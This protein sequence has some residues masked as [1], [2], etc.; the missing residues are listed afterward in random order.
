MPFSQLHFVLSLC[1]GAIVF[2]VTVTGWVPSTS[3]RGSV[4]TSVRA[5]PASYIPVYIPTSRGGGG[6]SGG[7]WSGG[8]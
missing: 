1:V 8:K 7:G 2:L 3:P 6:S 5:N 4:P